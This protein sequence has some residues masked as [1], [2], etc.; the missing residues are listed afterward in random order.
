MNLLPDLT[1]T[2]PILCYRLLSCRVATENVCRI[3]TP[4]GPVRDL[5]H[6]PSEVEATAVAPLRNN[7]GLNESLHANRLSLLAGETNDQSP[8]ICDPRGYEELVMEQ[9]VMEQPFPVM[10]DGNQEWGLSVE[11]ENAVMAGAVAVAVGAKVQDG[12]KEREFVP[13]Y[14]EVRAFPD[15]GWHTIS[16]T[17]T[18][19]TRLDAR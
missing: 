10:A 8:E 17:V 6:R 9:P 4:G 15:L 12:S 3:A 11:R 13:S 16:S 19:L 14:D 18:L 5:Q 1:L 7:Q 2:I